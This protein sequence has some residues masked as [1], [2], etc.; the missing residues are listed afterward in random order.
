MNNSDS[1]HDSTTVSYSLEEDRVR[2]LDENM[3][4][5]PPPD[6]RHHEEPP[7]RYEDVI[8]GQEEEGGGEEHRELLQPEGMEE[9]VREE[10]EEIKVV[11][12][13]MPQAED[14]IPSSDNA[15]PQDTPTTRETSIEFPLTHFYELEGRTHT[16]QW[17]IPYK[18]EE[19]LGVCMLATIRMMKEGAGVAEADENC[20]KFLQ[21]TMPSCFDKLLAHDAVFRWDESIMKGIREMTLIL[22]ELISVR[23]RYKPVPV[24]LLN[25]LSLVVRLTEEPF[26]PA[27]TGLKNPIAV[28]RVRAW[29]IENKV[30]SIA[31]G[32]NLHQ[33]QYC[34]KVKSIVEFLGTDLSTDE[35]N[36]IWDMQVDKNPAQ[37]ENIHNI[38]AYAASRFSPQHMDTLF[39][40]IQQSWEKASSDRYREKLLGL[41]GKIGKDDRTGKTASKILELLWGLA[42]LPQLSREMVELALDS[43]HSIL[44]ESFHTKDSDKRN[45]IGK[46]V[47]DIKKCQWVVS[48]LLQLHRLA[49]G[50]FRSSYGHKDQQQIA[51]LQKQYDLLRTV[52]GTMNK[53]HAKTV[54][55]CREKGEELTG[56]TIID[57]RYTQEEC[58]NAHLELLH[59]LLQDGSLY[60]PFKRCNEVWDTLIANPDACASD[61]RL[62]FKWFDR[63]IGDLES[64]TQQSLFTK[65]VLRVEPVLLDMAGYHCIRSFFETINL[66]E[67]KLRKLHSHQLVVDNP[68][69]TGIDYLWK[70]ALEVTDSIIADELISHILQITYNVLGPK[71]KKEPEKLHRRFIDECFTRLESLIEPVESLDPNLR[72]QC[73]ER[74]LLLAQ[75]Y[76]TTVECHSN[77]TLSSLRKRVSERLKVTLEQIQIGTTEKW[78]THYNKLLHQL[79]LTEEH[80]I[81]VKTTSVGYSSSSLDT[82]TERLKIALRQERLLPGVIMA[83]EKDI[84]TKLEQLCQSGE[85]RVIEAV[86]TLLSLIPI[87][88]KV[89]EALEVFV[90]PISTEGASEDTRLPPTPAA[91]LSDFYDASKVSPTQLLYNLEVLS[92]KLMPT[93][94]IT[95][96]DSSQ[97]FRRNFLEAEGL[98]VV[99]NILHSSNFP[100]ETD[101]TVRQDCYAITL[102]LARVLLCPPP[103]SSDTEGGVEGV[104]KPHLPVG[105]QMSRNVEDEVARHT[106]ETMTNDD[107]RT[108][109]SCL[110]R[111]CW[112]AGAGKLYLATGEGSDQLKSGLCSFTTSV[113]N[114]KD[115]SIAQ[116]SLELLV[117]CLKLRKN[118]LKIFYELSR[119]EEFVIDVLLGSSQ[120]DL[121]NQMMES[122]FDLCLDARFYSVSYEDSEDQSNQ[123][124]RPCPSPSET[125]QHFFLHLLLNSTPTLLLWKLTPPSNS[126][127]VLWGRCTEYF[128]FLSHLLKRLL[129]SEQ[130]SLSIDVHHMLKKELDWLSSVTIPPPPCPPVQTLLA[131]HLNL[132]R[133][134]MSCHGVDKS[135][136]T[137]TLVPDLLDNF[138]FPASHL[139]SQSRDPE[140]KGILNIEPKCS[141]VAARVAAYDLLIELST[142]CLANLKCVANRLIAMHHSCRPMNSKE[143]EFRPLTIGRSPCGYVGLKNAG[144]TCYMNTVLQQLYMQPGI[145]EAILGVE[146][147]EED[148]SILPDVQC[149]FGHLLESNLQY[150]TPDLFWKNFRLEGQ[151]VN[152]LEHQ[153]ASE[154]FSSLTDQIDETLK[155]RGHSK[156]FEERFGGQFLDQIICHGC[157][158]RFEKQQGFTSLQL[159]VVQSKSLTESLQEF[160]R[161]DMLEGDNRY[162]CGECQEKRDTLKRTCIKT[163]PPTL[164]VHLKRFDYDWET[165]REIKFNNYFEFPKTLDLEP[166]TAE[167]ITSREKGLGP[168][169]PL[170]YNLTGIIVHQG[171]ASA[172]HYYAFIK[173]K[174]KN[175]FMKATPSLHKA[176]PTIPEEEEMETIQTHP[177]QEEEKEE[178][179]WLKFNDTLVERFIIDEFTLET[180]C[181]G[182]SVRSNSSDPVHTSHPESRVRHWNAYMLFY[183][184]ANEIKKTQ[185]TRKE[186]DSPVTVVPTMSSEDNLSQLQE[187]VTKGEK[188]GVFNDNI[189]L[190]IQ[191]SQ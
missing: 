120:P 106:I 84:F 49:K 85:P 41:I 115:V 144:A 174:G 78:L 62:A 186:Q 64:D 161:G 145:R 188:R 191:R 81:I 50:M 170:I 138:L 7:P 136:Y 21:R 53:I 5:S 73:V 99:L 130:E 31:F 76:L 91:V 27:R 184:A 43:H 40:L 152:V 82:N 126:D 124:K 9:G 35:L 177:L 92:G 180:E 72:V 3:I 25:M 51:E 79:N 122:F 59:F 77:E 108:I 60:L 113:V 66:A 160:V 58:I 20:V 183:E 47:E 118:L 123:P 44:I 98:K 179:Q 134:L 36:T 67:R 16:D 147:D 54:A 159:S 157:E 127:L 18:R 119:V 26:S 39:Q 129:V 80:Q 88:Q 14:P 83:N 95:E 101:V 90:H 182:G 103:T 187:L 140:A 24:Y 12:E 111:V 128:I 158:H 178:E 75:R 181:F 42:H 11:V 63:S 143:W 156:V 175:T 168:S 22:M 100:P 137:D 89:L 164:V 52:S 149:I 165:N 148:S 96:V 86:R 105:R 4:D 93:N 1:D 8:E 68:D 151:P 110:M 15:T 121:R 97:T 32:G 185:D 135:S 172:G 94:Q 13:E 61:R 167:G 166:Y 33:A 17:S 102:T 169:S 133:A 10:E 153:D 70:A 131:G 125:P 114:S 29:L 109:L 132:I 112:S 142:D 154:F 190:T 28:E 37:V 6:G 189:P 117:T 173:T 71:L 107:F 74:L 57:G 46:C 116:E 38:L 34:D 56:N 163:P 19:S 171:Q 150:Y 141:D 146:R 45:Y 176:T 155:K 87:N 104:D 23:L 30:L 162:L 69:L 48:A 55:A 65:R 139:V 2:D